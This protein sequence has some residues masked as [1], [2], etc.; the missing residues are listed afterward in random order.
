MFSSSRNIISTTL[1]FSFLCLASAAHAFITPST[2]LM[3]EAGGFVAHQGKSQDIDIDT[4]IGNH[5]SVTDSNDQN[6]LLGLGLYMDA[7]CT[8]S[9]KLMAGINAYYLAPTEVKGNI[10]QEQLFQN[11]SYHYN[12]TNYPVYL[13][14][15]A[16]V[17][18][19][20][21]DYTLTVNGGLGANFI[22]A[23]NYTEK[24]EDGGITIPGASF[25]SHTQTVF[26]AMIGLGIQFNNL[27]CNTPIELSYQF[28]YLGNGY[29]KNGND[30]ILDNLDT[31]N[32]YANALMLT[33]AL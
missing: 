21:A 22:S 17:F 2:H 20:S 5:Y 31:G 19:G 27:F 30:A 29:L 14:G 9:Y 7:F 23:S 4:L 32:S 11:L 8:N 12:I 3:L 25:T 1:L 10:V 18:L 33:V 13:A 24:S 26:S 28:F 15:K 16:L 6:Y